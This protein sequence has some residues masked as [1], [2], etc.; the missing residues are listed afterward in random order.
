MNASMILASIPALLAIIA[1]SVF[2]TSFWFWFVSWLKK[3][4]A[5]AELITIQD[6]TDSVKQKMKDSAGLIEKMEIEAEA[7]ETMYFVR[8]ETE[9]RCRIIW[10]VSLVICLVFIAVFIAAI[11][12]SSSKNQKSSQTNTQHYTSSPAST[13]TTTDNTDN[14]GV[15]YQLP[16]GTTVTADDVYQGADGQYYLKSDRN[17]GGTGTTTTDTEPTNQTTPDLNIQF[18]E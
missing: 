13:G 14:S 6:R 15:I 16:D 17:P 10:S 11:N 12:G 9:R 4:T 5:Y 8:S 18:T 2:F 7:S 3:D 1:G